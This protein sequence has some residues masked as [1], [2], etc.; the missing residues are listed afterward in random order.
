MKQSPPTSHTPLHRARDSLSSLSPGTGHKLLAAR[1][2]YRTAFVS[3]RPPCVSSEDRLA[4]RRCEMIL[5]ILSTQRETAT[6]QL[7]CILDRYFTT[8]PEARFIECFA[9]MTFEHALKFSYD[10]AVVCGLIRELHI[11]QWVR[12]TELEFPVERRTTFRRHVLNQCQTLFRTS[13]AGKSI[14][15]LFA[16]LAPVMADT[17][18]RRC[19]LNAR[20]MGLLRVYDLINDSLLSAVIHGLLVGGETASLDRRDPETRVALLCAVLS[21]A[22]GSMKTPVVENYFAAMQAMIEQLPP[23]GSDTVRTTFCKLQELRNVGWDACGLA[24]AITA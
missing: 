6:A 9:I 15:V 10:M 17:H 18:R 22:G 4:I 13:S 24:E 1:S 8:D 16:S 20:F 21:G 19:L 2:V 14:S 3:M 7:K 23:S 5:S 11:Y 12:A